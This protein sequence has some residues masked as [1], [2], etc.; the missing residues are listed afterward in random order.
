[1]PIRPENKNLY[2]KNWAE[3][4]GRVRARA[5]NKCEVEGCG[6]RNHAIGYWHSSEKGD[7]IEGGSPSRSLRLIQIVCTTA[8]LDHNPENCKM[9][10]L[11]YMCQRCHNRYD[12]P[13]RAKGIKRRRRQAVKDAGQGEIFERSES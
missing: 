13:E 3:I 1:M 11:R 6:V 5:G 10:N 8:H 9:K 2:P 12:A 7:F 4:V